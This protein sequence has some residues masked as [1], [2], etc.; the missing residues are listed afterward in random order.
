MRNRNHKKSK[1]LSYWD[2]R[3]TYQRGRKH[4]QRDN[5][6]KLPKLRER[7]LSRYRRSKVTSQ[8]HPNQVYPKTY[9]SQALRLKMRWG[10]SKWPEKSHYQMKGSQLAQLQTAHQKP[11]SQ[12]GV[13]WDLHYW[14]KHCQPRILYP[15]K[16]SCRYERNKDVPKETWADVSTPHLCYIHD[17]LTGVLQAERDASK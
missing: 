14:K 1:Y 6:R 12:E 10:F 17:M 5:G 4:F 16:S 11:Y 2:T 8:S 3:G 9:Y 7:Q 15:A 13:G